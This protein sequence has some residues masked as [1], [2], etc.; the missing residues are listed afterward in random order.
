[1]SQFSNIYTYNQTYN[2]TA[3]KADFDK[4]T[5]DEIG[6]VAAFIIEFEK[7]GRPRSIAFDRYFCILSSEYDAN[8]Y[9]CPVEDSGL[10]H[11]NK[12]PL[13]NFVKSEENIKEFHRILYESSFRYKPGEQYDLIA[14]L[15]LNEKV[16][17]D[18]PGIKC[19]SLEFKP[20]KY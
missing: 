1:M 13:L 6:I 14:K 5:E 8:R 7:E 20:R 19:K 11:I 12:I 3:A 2:M 10:I 18:I 17:K 9:V 16:F 4:T 15:E